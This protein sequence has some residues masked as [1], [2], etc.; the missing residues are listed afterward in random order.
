MTK[1]I[2]PYL[3]LFTGNTGSIIASSSKSAVPNLFATRD[4]FHGRSFFPG[5]GW[6][7]GRTRIRGT[8]RESSGGNVTGRRE[9]EDP[10]SKLSISL[11]L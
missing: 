3:Q 5:G 1:I 4:W 6:W 10:S 9:V 7:G 11:P 8:R 2:Y